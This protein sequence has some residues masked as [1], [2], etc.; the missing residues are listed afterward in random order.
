MNMIP[1]WQWNEIQQ[2]G[3]D[4]SNL[5]QV[6]IYDNRMASFRDVNAENQE[7][8]QMLGLAAGSA[9]L[10]IGCGTG[11][12][13]RYA[14]AAGLAV[15][16]IDVSKIM[17][18]YVVKKAK[19]ENLPPIT[20]RHSGFLT[21]DFPDAS[22]DAVVSGAALHHLPDVWKLVA[23]RNIA[24]ILKPQGQFILRD[25]VFS[26]KENEQP[27]DCF[28]RFIASFN[29]QV[30]PNAIGHIKTEYSTYD[31]IM[32]GLIKMAGFRIISKTNPFESFFV[33]HCIRIGDK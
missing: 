21:M 33:Y 2:I 1:D 11:R 28:D 17:L 22:F 24:R 23:L 13:A 18:D 31:W 20:T 5:S 15:T 8:L 16:A 26:L 30:R 29:E 9:V 25:V 27:K 3:T 19:D 12:F 7:M 14:A 6:E 4:Y 32:E 10:E